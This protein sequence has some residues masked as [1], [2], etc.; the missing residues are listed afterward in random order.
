MTERVVVG[1]D[2]GSGAAR[3]IAAN[4]SGEIVS[5]SSA[6]YGMG[7]QPRGEA[8]PAAWLAGMCDA[9]AKLDSPTPDAI[10]VGGHGPTTVAQDGQR[11]L[12]F[13]HPSAE[14]GT[15]KEQHAAQVIQLRSMLG[16]SLQPRQLWDWLLAQI[17]GSS[18]TQGVWPRSDA[19]VDFG[20]P[21][22]VGSCV[23]YT[24]GR[25]G[26]P[27]G[28][29]LVPGSN[30]G[31]MTG[32][33]AGIG[34]PGRAFDP[35]GK[36]GGLGLAVDALRFPD[37]A[38]YGMPSA[39]AGVN[40]VG[41]P[42]AAHGAML[43]WWSAITGRSIPDLLEIAQGIPPGSQGVMLLPYFEGERAPRWNPAL[44][45]TIVGLH[46]DH[47]VA[48]VSRAILESTG[49]GLAHIARVLQHQGME[50]D[51][52]VCSGK[53]SRSRTWVAIK[54]AILEAPIDIPECDDMAAYGA[55]L[56]A[57]AA[58]DWWPGPGEGNTSDW[59]IPPMTTIEPEPNEV[60]RAGL[61]RFIAL[62]D[63]ATERLS[64]QDHA[65][66]FNTSKEYAR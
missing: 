21:V 27:K 59:P 62:G 32:W 41:G 4:R 30:D 38:E 48:V 61:D 57:G 33:A 63:A 15:P 54:A 44:R 39:V 11:A 16:E 13:R 34:V 37:T 42:V 31:N 28:I 36:T 8:D 10:C 50:L 45:G 65:T 6:N 51:R 19:L 66:T 1:L 17:G 23:G 55:V 53:P 14:D 47:D 2:I 60:Y 46:I 18:E 3:A 49:Y 20:E 58:I 43:D 52:V 12:T 7:S 29:A 9:L 5:V 40:I 35:G 26:L 56:G 25:Y 24:D 64:T 22:P